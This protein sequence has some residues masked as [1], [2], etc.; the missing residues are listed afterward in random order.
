MVL[1]SLHHSQK[2]K[3]VRD[4]CHQVGTT[5]RILEGSTQWVN[6]AELYVGLME[7]LIRKDMR[8]QNSPLVFWDY[9]AERRA[10]ITNM[11]AKNMFQLQGQTPHFATFGEQG[12]ISNI[13]QFGWYG[14][15][16]FRC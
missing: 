12:D 6:R 13:C 3:E 9:C 16:Y 2:S 4:F 5:L 15:V 1:S 11:T 7:E 8:D 14:W 10:S